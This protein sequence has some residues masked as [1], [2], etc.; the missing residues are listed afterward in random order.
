MSDPVENGEPQ[1]W[2]AEPVAPAPLEP[3]DAA[4]LEVEPVADVLPIKRGHPLLAWLVIGLLVVLMMLR[5]PRSSM[6]QPGTPAAPNNPVQPVPG[7]PAP[8]VNQRAAPED[9]HASPSD[10]LGLLVLTMQSKFF[11]GYNEFA[12][13]SDPSAGKTLLNQADALNVGPVVNRLCYVVLAGELADSRDALQ[14]LKELDEKIAD[15]DRIQDKHVLRA[16]E[17]LERL[18]GDYAGGMLS[19]P[20][21]GAE[22]RE[23]LQATLGWFADLA[24]APRGGPNPEV[25]QALISSTQAVFVVFIVVMVI[26]ALV[27]LAGLIGL[28]TL[29]GFQLAGNLKRGVVTG[30]GQGGIYAETFAL[31]MVV[32]LVFSSA[33][34]FIRAPGAEM[35]VTGGSILASLIVL[36]WPVFRGGIPWRQVRQ[37]IGLVA[38]R[39]PLLEPLLG[40]AGY[41][42]SLPLLAV[43]VVITLFLISLQ[44]VMGPMLGTMMPA[45]EF[46]PA[47]FPA[48]PIIE[49]L[50]GSGWWG[51]FQVLFLGSVVAPIVEETMFR[52][53]LYRHL[54]ESTC[55]WPLFLS[56]AASALV[57]SFVFAAIHPQGLLAVPAL[58]SLAFGFTIMREWRGS[59]ISCMIAHGLN[60]A[61]VMSLAAFV[62]NI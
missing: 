53:V 3:S 51:I 8:Q 28:F 10:R 25:R 54:R 9:Q 62:F 26:G 46:S 4:V 55:R 12:R 48:H 5:E 30:G 42:M 19:G 60:N 34:Y 27:G 37:D 17:A 16:K 39:R 7:A 31:W 33:P 40:P 14:K 21:V 59:L 45:D 22:D 32:F 13:A 50:A 58:M 23:N 11:V 18:Y 57:V 47:V 20:S 2:P 6:H 36:A 43:G 49:M 44:G 61:L 41:A 35:L 24:L 15:S 56:F 38:G 1:N 52:G 29:I